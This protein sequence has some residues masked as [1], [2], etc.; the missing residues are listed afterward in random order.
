MV[1]GSVEG[2]HLDVLVG[3]VDEFPRIFLG[4]V[5]VALFLA[6][7]A[8]GVYLGVVFEIVCYDSLTYLVEM[9]NWLAFAVFDSVRLYLGHERYQRFLCGLWNR[10]ALDAG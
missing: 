6:A 5:V 1:V 4:E 10:H 9:G 8:E 3:S 7:V 2:F